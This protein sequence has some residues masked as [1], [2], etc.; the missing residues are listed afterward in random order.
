MSREPVFAYFCKRT[1]ASGVF[2]AM[3]YC[4]CCHNLITA[5]G[6]GAGDMICEPCYGWING[7]RVA[8]DQLVEERDDL[9]YR[10]ESL[11]K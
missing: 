6:S 2:R 4:Y 9:Q 3:T 8:F 5:A 7:A 1:K 11:D 10:M